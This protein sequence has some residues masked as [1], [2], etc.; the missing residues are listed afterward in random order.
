MV[1]DVVSQKLPI[2]ILLFMSISQ[3]VLVL[4]VIQACSQDYLDFLLLTG[5]QN[6]NT[7]CSTLLKKHHILYE[8]LFQ[9]IRLDIARRWR[10]S[11]IHRQSSKSSK[12]KWE[13]WKIIRFLCGITVPQV[14]N[15]YAENW[16]FDPDTEKVETLTGAIQMV[17]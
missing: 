10:G 13:F 3:S 14:R 7:F 17:I 5:D 11:K 12:R 8:E 15:L 9:I 6:H 1:G 4:V 2:N 16:Y